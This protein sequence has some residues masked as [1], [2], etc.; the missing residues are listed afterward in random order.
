MEWRAIRPLT[1]DTVIEEFEEYIGY[2]FSD[3]FKEFIRAYN[4]GKPSHKVFNTKKTRERVFND[5]LS[6]N[7]EDQN[8][9]WLTNDRKGFMSDW[10]KDGMMENYVV[11]AEDAFGNLICFDISDSSIV[12]IDHENKEAEYISASFEKFIK[13]LKKLT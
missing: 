1:S 7:K 11:F 8:N 6:F 5:L 3:T 2:R 12:L 4:G 13:G 9:I 10:N